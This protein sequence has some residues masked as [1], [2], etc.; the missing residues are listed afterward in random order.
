MKNKLQLSASRLHTVLPKLL[1]LC[2][3][4]ISIFTTYYATG[5]FLDS[6][7]C[8]ELVLANHWIETGKILSTDWFYATELRFLHVQLVYV[9][10]MLLLDDWQMVRFLGALIMQALYILS[11][12][13]LVRASGKGKN[14]FLYGA[15]LLLLPVSVT[16]G[17]IVLYHNHY[18]PNIVVAFFL[19]ALSMHFTDEVDWKSKKT[20]LYLFLLASLSFSAGINSIRQL[21][22]THAPLIVT[23]VVFCWMDDARNKDCTTTAFLK[24]VNLNYLL[25]CFYSAAFSFF[26]LM[27]QGFLCS[28]RGIHLENHSE[29]NILSF[30]GFDNIPNILYGYFHQFGYREDVSMLSVSGILSLGGILIGCYLLFLS[31]N[32]IRQCNPSQSRR[33]NLLSL[34]FSAH[35]AVMMLVFLLTRSENPTYYYPLYLSLCF[36]WAVP[37]LL[38]NLE[39]LPAAIHPLR[40][41]KLFALISIILLL[42]SGGANVLYFQGSDR[43]PQTYEG[44]GFQNKDKKEELAE[45]VDF[46]TEQGYDKGYATHWECNIVTEMTDGRIPMVSILNE[47][48]KTSGNLAYRN[49]LSPLW[50]REAPCEKPFLLLSEVGE[51]IFLRSNSAQY[52]TKIYSGHHH[53]AYSIDNLIDFMDT[54]R[55]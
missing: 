33:I 24:P 35:T 50:N 29:N 28:R 18:L 25:C 45:V 6:D 46:L 37:L 17:R 44:L 7:T 2:S 13:C 23:A 27:I 30:V 38:L 40:T 39:E 22:I 12:G 51:S 31:I 10:L 11:F 52:C 54:L 14:F 32:R 26:G 3:V 15:S 47:D 49:W 55:Y 20:W 48:L 16:Y 41:K 34:F 53:V 5:H 8:S 36:P 4:I 43:F 9:P 21:M 1:F 19:L 42:L